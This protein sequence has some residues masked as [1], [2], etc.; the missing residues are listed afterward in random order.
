M[1]IEDAP[2]AIFDITS[3]YSLYINVLLPR[4]CFSTY[5]PYFLTLISV[6]MKMKIFLLAS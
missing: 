6:G 4:L 5:G 3:Y 2:N 1:L